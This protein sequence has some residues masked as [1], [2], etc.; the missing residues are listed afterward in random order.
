MIPGPVNLL[1]KGAMKDKKREHLKGKDYI[2]LFKSSMT[3]QS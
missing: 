2:L 1:V 3:T